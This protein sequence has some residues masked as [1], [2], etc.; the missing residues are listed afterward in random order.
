DLNDPYYA[1]FNQ[2]NRYY[3][4]ALNLGT[5]AG[6]G[7]ADFASTYAGLSNED[8]VF[9]AYENIVGTA[10][11]ISAGIDPTAARGDIVGRF[12]FFRA[13]AVERGGIEDIP[14]NAAA[15]DLAAKAVMVA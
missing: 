4:F 15:I 7:A 13:V 14:A 2:E 8:A 5:G 1:D 6:E 12:D 3:N 10:A 9:V 11:A